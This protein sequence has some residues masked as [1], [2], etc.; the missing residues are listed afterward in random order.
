[1]LSDKRFILIIF[2]L[3]ALV[4]WGAATP[5]VTVAQDQLQIRD[6]LLMQTPGACLPA[7]LK[8]Q[9]KTQTR[10]KLNTTSPTAVTTSQ[11]QQTSSP[12]VPKTRKQSQTQIHV[13]TPP[14][15]MIQQRPRDRVR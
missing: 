9:L 5:N 8:D 15:N 13:V 1:M 6:R 10:D 3:V 7:P 2:A 11:T 4:A 14:G 12:P